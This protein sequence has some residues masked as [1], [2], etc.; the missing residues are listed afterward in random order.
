LTTNRV[1]TLNARGG[2][3]G[4]PGKN[5]ASVAGRSLLSYSI[6]QAANSGL[7]EAVAVSSDSEEILNEAAKCGALPIL[8]PVELATDLAPKVPS[9]IHCVREVE[10]HKGLTFSTVVDLDVTSPLRRVE[11]IVGAVA[12]L[13]EGGHDS[14][15]TATKA[16]RSPYFNQVTKHSDGSWGPVILS[17]EPLFRRQDAPETFDMNASI[18]VWSR[19]SLLQGESVFLE[20]TAMYLMPEERSW[21]IDSKFDFEIV[22]LLLERQVGSLER[23]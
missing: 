14:V 8:R 1:C 22:S 5:L 3:K 7:F 15:F 23:P 2:S 21:D 18:Y 16:R 9:I 13:E 20:S 4:V 12:L 17:S 19:N 6:E 10:R 11:D